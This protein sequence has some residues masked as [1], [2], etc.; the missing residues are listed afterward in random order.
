MPTG[1]YR[2]FP[3]DTNFRYLAEGAAN[4]VYRFSI[5]SSTPPPSSI[6]EYGDDE[7]M[8]TEFEAIPLWL[9]EYDSK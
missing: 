5:L 3:E 2:A 4:I 7:P 9:A 8:P 1:T 6:E